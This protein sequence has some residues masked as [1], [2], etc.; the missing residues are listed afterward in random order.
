MV[1]YNQ[2]EE[3]KSTEE[4]YR[5]MLQKVNQEEDDNETI[6]KDMVEKYSKIDFDQEDEFSRQFSAF[7]L[8]GETMR[9]DSLLRTKG[10]ITEDLNKFK[11]FQDANAQKRAEQAARDSLEN[12]SKKELAD[13][14]HKYFELFKTQHK[15]DSAAYYIEQ[16]ASLDTLNADWQFDAAL[17]YQ[18]QKQFKQSERYYAR[19]LETYR[20]LAKD[21]PQ[22]HE[23]NLAKTL[24]NMVT[25]Y[26]RTQR[27]DEAETVCKE[28]L[29]I[30]T[31]LA[32]DNAQT[33]ER[34]VATTLN[35]LASV[36][37]AVQRF[38]EAEEMYKRALE[39][40]RQL[41]KDNSQTEEQ[42]LAITLSNLAT[43]YKDI[44]RLEE[45]EAMYKEALEI[46]RR[47]AK[48]NPQDYECDVADVLNGLAILCYATQRFDEV[49]AMFK[50]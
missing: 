22:A 45:A 42:N 8:N 40:R 26:K 17:Y 4:K 25:V 29:E 12:R 38:N 37:Y 43:L 50:E 46:S 20:Q 36:Y 35:N 47:L 19:A 1:I 2:K 49:E 33:Y 15:N 23:P 18:D 9:A 31:R 48:A 10:D 39:I 21:N 41:A 3:N 24:N 16:R 30:R 7:L 5:E 28:A 6:I 14:C 44:Q 11:A 34:D 27:F 13:R 32:K